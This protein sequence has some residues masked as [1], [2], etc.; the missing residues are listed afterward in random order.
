MNHGV[1]IEINARYRLPSPTFIRQ[2]KKSGVKFAF[3]T[4]NSGPNDLGTLDYCL[5]MIDECGLTAKDM[6]MPKDKQKGR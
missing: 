1:A 4:N 5:E 2:A 3:G 6:F